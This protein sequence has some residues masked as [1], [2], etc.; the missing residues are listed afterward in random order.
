MKLALVRAGKKAC[1]RTGCSRAR[2]PLGPA[3]D[4]VRLKDK[5]IFTICTSYL[6]G[7]DAY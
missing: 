2:R 3:L 5:I 6:Q 4:M 7:G 1:W